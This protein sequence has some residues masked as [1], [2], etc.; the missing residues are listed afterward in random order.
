MTRPLTAKLALDLLR[1]RHAK[2]LFVAECKNGPTVGATRLLRLD[3]WVFR[4]TW[5]PPTTIGY[6]I[7]MSRQDFLGDEKWRSY[8]PLCHQLNFV[9]PAKLIE[10]P[11]LPTDVGLLWITSGGGRLYTKRKAV[12]R[13]IEPAPFLDLVYY[14]LMHRVRIVSETPGLTRNRG[15]SLAHWREWVEQRAAGCRLGPEIRGKIRESHNKLL[16]DNAELRQ[17]IE[18]YAEVR[19]RIEEL[20]LP[21]DRPVS[22]WLA[23]RKVHELLDVVDARVVESVRDIAVRLSRLGD[24]LGRLRGETRG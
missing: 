4:P 20:G 7:K 17:C 3:A 16:A 18:S 23:E 19:R 21:V 5:V 11:E 6:E 22:A 9:C 24:D 15:D 12:Y 2:D 10:P 8:L 1:E 14:V 13:E